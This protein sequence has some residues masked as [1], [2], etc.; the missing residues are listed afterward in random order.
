MVGIYKITNL[1]NNKIYIG[2]SINIQQRWMAHRHRPFNINSSQYDTPLYRAIRKY[3]LQNFSFEILEECLEKELDSKEQYYIEK[4]NTIN[5]DKGYNL[6]KGGQS[7]SINTILSDEEILQIYNLLMNSTLTETDIANRFNV[8]QRYISGINLGQYRIQSGYIY[9]LKNYRK[10]EE[11]HIFC[12]KCGVEISTKGAKL[13]VQ[14]STQ[15]KRVVERPSREQ[16]KQEIRENS[17]LSLG[18]KYSVSDNAIRKWCKAYG[19]PTQKTIIKKISNEDW[20][21]I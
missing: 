5:P 16:L 15:E 10:K 11:K 9:P 2:Q 18:K 20:S 1:I 12:Q 19:L 8:S 4:Y 14:C 13:C 7:G 3:G 6:T 17:F 21:K